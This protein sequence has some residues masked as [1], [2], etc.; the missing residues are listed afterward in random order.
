MIGVLTHHWAKPDKLDEARRL[1]DSIIPAAGRAY[2]QPKDITVFYNFA[3]TRGDPAWRRRELLAGLLRTA[4]VHWWRLKA[5]VLR[6]ALETRR[7]VVLR[8]PVL[9][10]WLRPP[11]LS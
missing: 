2:V 8:I 6:A 4:A 11:T 3:V 7:E 1:L 10:R 5:P 9:R